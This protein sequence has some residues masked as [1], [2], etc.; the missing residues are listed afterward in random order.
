MSITLDSAHA[1]RRRN[2]AEWVTGILGIFW[3]VW[4]GFFI[5]E[6]LTEPNLSFNIP[7]RFVVP[8]SYITITKDAY[9]LLSALVVSYFAF[10][11][12]HWLWNAQKA[13]YQRVLLREFVVNAKLLFLSSL[14]L[15]ASIG[16]PIA[17]PRISETLLGYGIVLLILW[18][19]FVVI[20]IW[21]D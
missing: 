15:I 5:N 4:W 16:L 12:A 11:Y 7:L 19:I 17:N 8:N 13:A 1:E 2:L 3:S 6:I 9:L 20:T 10:T 14:I 21:T 18:P